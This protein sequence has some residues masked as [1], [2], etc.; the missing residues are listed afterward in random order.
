MKNIFFEFANNQVTMEKKTKASK[1]MLNIKN[2]EQHICLA[3][4]T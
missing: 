3:H 4:S 2:S 1:T